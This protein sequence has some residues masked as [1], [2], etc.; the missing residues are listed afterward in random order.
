[1]RTWIPVALVSLFLGGCSVVLPPGQ[2]DCGGT[3]IICQAGQ[4]CAD[5]TFGTCEN[6]CLSNDNCSD[7]QT[8]D[9]DGGSPGTCVNIGGGGGGGTSDDD[10]G[11][12]GGDSSENLDVCQ[13]ACDDLDFF[14]VEEGEATG[15]D[16]TDCAEACVDG[17]PS[18]RSAQA[19]CMNLPIN[20]CAVALACF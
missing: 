9:L 12:G 2:T 14:C 18:D 13:D 5:P 17:S 20:E 6:G 15:Q 3:G 4:Y 1:M 8:C 16:L 19:Q 7:D 10:T 11:G